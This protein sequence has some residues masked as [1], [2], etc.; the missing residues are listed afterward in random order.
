MTSV[1]PLKT[2]IG[3]VKRKNDETQRL[4]L[5]IWAAKKEV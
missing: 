1:T 3:N 4:T 2:K 5:C